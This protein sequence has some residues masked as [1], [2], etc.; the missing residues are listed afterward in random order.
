MVSRSAYRVLV[1]TTEGNRPIG[2]PRFRWEYNSRKYLWSS[3]K[4]AWNGQIRL[5]TGPRGG[6]LYKTIMNLRVPLMEEH[7]CVVLLLIERITFKNM[8]RKL[9]N[10]SS[11][12]AFVRLK[13]GLVVQP[14]TMT[15]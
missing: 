10:H 7:L 3:V 1:G 9:T 8:F 4:R 15:T 5:R 11:L 12:G 14:Q 13:C 2:R 6:M